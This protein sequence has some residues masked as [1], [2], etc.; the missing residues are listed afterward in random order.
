MVAGR[1]SFSKG[2]PSIIPIRDT[3]TAIA[4]KRR[5]LPAAVLLKV[6][7]SEEQWLANPV[8]RVEGA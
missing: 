5:R 6:A 3:K 7:M 1:T 8:R 4:E 2:C